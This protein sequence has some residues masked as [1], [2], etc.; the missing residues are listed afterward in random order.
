MINDFYAD[1]SCY[2]HYQ[3]EEGYLFEDSRRTNTLSNFEVSSTT[4]PGSYKEGYGAAAF[5]RADSQFFKIEDSDLCTGFP[6]KWK[7][8]PTDRFETPNYISF[9]FWYYPITTDGTQTLIAKSNQADKKCFE[10]SVIDSSLF[11]I[12]GYSGSGVAAITV[13]VGFSF[14]PEHWYHVGVSI[15]G[16]DA[17]AHVRIW[18]DT[19]QL[20]VRNFLVESVGTDLATNDSPLT[21][22]ADYSGS[23]CIDAILDEFVI[24]D[25]ERTSV[26]FDAIRT[27]TYTGPR[28]NSFVDDPTCKALY[29]FESGALLTDS[30]GTNHLSDYNT[31]R[32]S[33]LVGLYMEGKQSAYFKSSY[34][35]YALITDANLAAG[36]PLKSTDTTKT[37][38][39]CFWF[40]STTTSG[41]AYL[42]NKT[43][44]TSGQKS[45]AVYR[46]GASLRM[47]WGYSN[48]TQTTEIV[49]G[50]ISANRWYHVGISLAGGTKPYL[51]YR[52][53]DNVS[54]RVI[55]FYQSHPGTP[56]SVGAAPLVIASSYPVGNF[57][58]GYIDEVV[59]FADVKTATEID[60]IRMGAYQRQ[61][62][63]VYVDE[64][65]LT[66]D[67]FKKPQHYVYAVGV[68]L[69]Y[70]RTPQWRCGGIGVM[71]LAQARLRFISNRYWSDPNCVAC[72]SFERDDP[73]LLVDHISGN[74]LTDHNTIEPVQ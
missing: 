6:L 57:F 52:V 51:I 14:T 23:N 1:S 3:F 74:N 15:S 13:N 56:I 71:I 18:N 41:T 65:G 11:L 68:S 58:D 43:S 27:Q 37:F 42:I 62:L 53:W 60:Q 26:E 31:V 5:H 35:E 10:L 73:G 17:V 64:S 8:S 9:C 12:W 40:R 33:E 45:F 30:I 20:I 24:F 2:A 34:L 25:I 44:T 22:G 4:G 39:V 38:S 69:P 50:N 47:L 49:I 32:T 67:S 72:Y 36:F 59:I 70:E 63:P 54:R 19:S 48:G 46:V 66:V 61:L 28:Q 29:R 21:I 55:Y 16:P 7:S